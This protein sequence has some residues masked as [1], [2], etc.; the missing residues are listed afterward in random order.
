MGPGDP[1]LSMFHDVLEMLA[2]TRMSFGRHDA[3]GLEKAAA[4]G[5]DV[6]G[7]EKSLTEQ[8]LAS[9]PEREG[10]RFVPSHLERASDSIVGLIRCLRDMEAEGTVFT[11]RGVREINQLFEK[12]TDLLECAR[13]LT[14]TGNQVL[15]RHVEIESLRFHDLASE[16]ARAHEERLIEGLCMPKASSAYLAMVDYLREVT[17]HARRIAG[18]VVR[19]ERAVSPF[20][21]APRTEIHRTGADR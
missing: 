12:A 6:H 17:R 9:Q 20:S 5:R 16:V 4:L 8:L 14:L 18:R 7:R 19:P 15:A 11:E 13:D 21:D 3:A 2:L 1:L 10:I